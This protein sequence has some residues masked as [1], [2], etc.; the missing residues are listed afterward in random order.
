MGNARRVKIQ[1]ARLFGKSGP[2]LCGGVFSGRPRKKNK[3]ESEDEKQE[4]LK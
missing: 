1:K 3:A 2:Q 4:R